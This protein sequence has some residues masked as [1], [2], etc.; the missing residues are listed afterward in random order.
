[1]LRRAAPFGHNGRMRRFLAP[2]LIAWAITGCAKR[3]APVVDSASPAPGATHPPIAART[4]EAALG[5]PV[6]RIETAEGLVIEDLRIGY[7]E[8][9]P[10]GATAEVEF[11]ASYTDGRIWD[12]SSARGRTL[13]LPLTSRS[14]IRGLREG[15][16]GMRVGGTRRLTIPW[17]LAYGEAGRDPIPPKTDLVFELTLV[18][19]TP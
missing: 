1:M 12:S 3:T 2:V 13:H 11:T 5:A 18:R 6:S 7:G 16:P 10:P 19:L 8:T 15:I 17:R 14:L 4:D 9:C